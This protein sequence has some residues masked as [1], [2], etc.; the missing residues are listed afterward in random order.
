[1]WKCK[2]A[3]IAVIP[4]AILLQ[5]TF[6][7]VFHRHIQSTANFNDAAA[8]AELPSHA[9]TTVADGDIIAA[10]ESNN[11]RNY[12][13][14][15]DF[16]S[17]VVSLP[18]LSASSPGLLPSLPSKH[19]VPQEVLSSKSFEKHY[20]DWDLENDPLPLFM[21][22]PSIVPLFSASS[23][24]TISFKNHGLEHGKYLATFRLSSVHSC[25]FPTVEFW[26]KS[27]NYLGLAILDD[28]LQ[29]ATLQLGTNMTD[30]SSSLDMIVD[31]N[32]LLRHIFT[33]KGTKKY[34]VFE[35][36]R[37]F[38]I[39]NQLYMS[40]R[41][42]LFPICITID[43]RGITLPR[44][45]PSPAMCKGNSS[46]S[47]TELPALYRN[48]DHLR[49]YIAGNALYLNCN[50]TDC[51]NFQFFEVKNEDSDKSKSN[52]LK[53]HWASLPRLIID[54]GQ[55]IYKQFVEDSEYYKDSTTTRKLLPMKGNEIISEYLPM[56]RSNTSQKIENEIGKYFVPR[57]RG[58]ACCVQIEKKYYEDFFPSNLPESVMV[59]ITHKK[60]ALRMPSSRGRKSFIYL[61][62][63]YAFSSYH[64][65]QY[66]ARSG[67]FCFGFA[68]N[69][70]DATSDSVASAYSELTK[71]QR[72]EFH[73]VSYDC[74]RIH[75][76]SGI[77]EKV[78]DDSRVIVAYGVNDCVSRFVEIAK[79]D[80]M[81]HL[82]SNG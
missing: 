58:S 33:G 73:G 29:V 45:P 24:S 47:M 30:V 49:L 35:D 13:Y 1:M 82:L 77:T 56:P 54:H 34:F 7:F 14:T 17:L 3:I 12:E 25:G 60:T 81:I 51:K 28:T 52:T 39:H 65:Y 63:L 44:T 41:M 46:S 4:F 5:G 8:G 53:E 70:T 11:K 67:L 37:L 9:S 61:S 64:P 74:P 26:K 72:V 48:N 42:F 66:I 10:L 59:G 31:I 27:V 22:N 36:V 55:D 16:S 79:R 71:V 38:I 50:T 40:I 80:L 15:P 2:G 6:L 68:N 21:Y 62:N 19:H 43:H 76:V 69:Q 57:D 78:G 75:F 18:I 32:S 20:S 23:H